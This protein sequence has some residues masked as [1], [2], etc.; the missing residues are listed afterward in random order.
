M[1]ARLLISSN[2]N[3]RLKLIE[4]ILA[5]EGLKN[6]HPDLL[7]FPK[8]SKLGIE[9]A[10]IIKGHFSLK[11]YQS[12]GRAVVLEDASN[13]TIDAQN[14]LL[15]TLEELPENALFILGS[16]SDSSLLPTVV[17]R[18]QIEFLTTNYQSLDFARDRLPT[19]NYSQDLEKLLKSNIGERF[20][21][22]EKLKDRK[23]FLY[24]LVV[25]FREL[26]QDSLT[27]NPTAVGKNVN[28][29]QIKNFI[30]ELLQAEKWLAQNVNIR[31]ILEYLMLVMP[32]KLW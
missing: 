18:C 22:I 10:R 11:P 14:A 20:D 24:F 28:S 16:N 19:T 4:E 5:E 32:Q 1:I 30:E 6:P 9:Q 27:K 15:K 13:L 23:E 21:Y 7:Y 12:K 3:N 17:S 26:L 29:T 25:Y 8:D 2:L 31:T